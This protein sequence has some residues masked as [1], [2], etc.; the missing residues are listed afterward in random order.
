MPGFS[1]VVPGFSEDIPDDSDADVSIAEVG[2]TVSVHYTGTLDDG[3]IFDTSRESVARENDIYNPARVYSPLEFTLGSG[4]MIPGFDRAVRGITP[5]ETKTVTIPPEEAYGS[6]TV[7]EE[8]ERRFL[9][10]VIVQTVPRSRFTDT[11]TQSVPLSQL[12]DGSSL[13]VGDTID[14][15]SDISATVVSIDDVSATLE[16]ENTANPFRGQELAVGLAGEFQGNPVR[17]TAIEEDDITLEI[18]NR[19]SPFFGQTLAVGLTGQT[20]EGES[21]TIVSLDDETARIQMPN[22]HEL[23]GESLTFEIELVAITDDVSQDSADISPSS[24][25]DANGDD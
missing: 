18:E 23:A 7:E 24:S 19:A 16:I 10:D 22:T 15:P 6:E 1:G 4:Q 11:V 21:V 25:P 5:G 9:E 12:P 8:I 13:S 14:L 17:I 3:T 2:D 20:T